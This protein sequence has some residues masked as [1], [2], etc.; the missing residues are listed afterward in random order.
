MSLFLHM[1]EIL[2]VPIL[3][4]KFVPVDE[5]KY[6]RSITQTTLSVIY[7]ASQPKLFF[8]LVSRPVK[9]NSLILSRGKH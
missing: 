9:I 6:K 4:L 2:L 7:L 1:F 3:A 8:Y 5:K